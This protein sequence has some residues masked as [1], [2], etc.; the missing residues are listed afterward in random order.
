MFACPNS[1]SEL[2]MLIRRSMK[3]WRHPQERELRPINEAVNDALRVVLNRVVHA[4]HISSDQCPIPIIAYAGESD[5]V[6]TPAS[7]KGVFPRTGII[8]GDHFTIVQPDSANHRAYT[9]LKANLLE[10]LPASSLPT[11]NTASVTESSAEINF[12]VDTLEDRS[13]VIA[14][15]LPMTIEGRWSGKLCAVRVI[16]EDSY[17]QYYVQDPDVRLLPDGTWLATNVIPGQ[18]IIYIHFVALGAEGKR[19]FEQMIEQR[20]FGAFREM[21]P[22]GRILH[23]LR[24]NRL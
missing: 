11:E 21:P 16:L 24:I 12:S 23:S 9:T 22:D 15:D 10:A 2:F 6:V 19:R 3:G 20:D 1:G 7:A 4:T 17:R 13:T 14:S 18:G 5:N 8:P